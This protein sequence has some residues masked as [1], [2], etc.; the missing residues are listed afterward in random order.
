MNN[1][2][3][4]IISESNGDP[5]TMRVVTLLGTLGI[6]GTWIFESISKGVLLPFGADM[7]TAIGILISGKVFQKGK[8]ASK[9]SPEQGGN[10]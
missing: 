4:Q 5:S 1:F 7:Q 2:L 8:E 10:P 3:S 9:P 6:I